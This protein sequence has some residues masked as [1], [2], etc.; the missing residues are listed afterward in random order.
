MTTVAGLRASKAWAGVDRE[1]DAWAVGGIP[2]SLWIR[3]DDAVAATLLSAD[4]LR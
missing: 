3:D 1:L 2:A 4:W